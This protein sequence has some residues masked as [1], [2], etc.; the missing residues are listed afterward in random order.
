[1]VKIN[2]IEALKKGIVGTQRKDTST[3]PTKELPKSPI[4]E[5][6][7]SPKNYPP[8]S[9]KKDLRQSPLRKLVEVPLI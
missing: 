4:T 3:V 9:I 8:K 1:M 6:L 2:V 7:H 5:I